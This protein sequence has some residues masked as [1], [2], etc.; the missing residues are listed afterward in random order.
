MDG[1]INYFFD[2]TNY[3]PQ[4]TK[5]IHYTWRITSNE[6]RINLINRH[7]ENYGKNF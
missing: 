6:H 7:I 2:G 1:N 5:A 3:Y 4:D